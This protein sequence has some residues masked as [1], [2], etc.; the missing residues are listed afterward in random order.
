MDEEATGDCD[1]KT[2]IIEGEKVK[3][4]PFD[5]EREKVF[6]ELWDHQS[7]D[8]QPLDIIP[9]SQPASPIQNE[10]SENHSLNG[11]LF[12]MHTTSDDKIIGFVAL[13][14]F[15]WAARSGWVGIG[16]GDEAYKGKGYGTEAMRLLL[17]YA[18]DGLNLNRLNL[19]VVSYN[20]RAI[21]SYEQVGFRY[22]GTQR[23][24][25]L[26]EEQRWDIVD[27]GILRQD[28]EL[29][30]RLPVGENQAT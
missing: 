21:R 9:V 20:E 25:I 17:R 30:N 18:F 27:M 23:E 26:K 6:W 3:L 28:W 1:M 4:V 10:N 12:I 24:V 13:D 8:F 29:L 5:H 22:E 7:N 15:D 11:A 19:N 14:G 16:I 2:D